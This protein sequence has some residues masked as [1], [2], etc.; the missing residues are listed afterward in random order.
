MKNR[1]PIN[2]PTW[3]LY[4][5]FLGNKLFLAFAHSLTL[6]MGTIIYLSQYHPSIGLP[7]IYN[8]NLVFLIIIALCFA[9]YLIFLFYVF[10]IRQLKLT[11]KSL[12]YFLAIFLGIIT[13]LSLAVFF[14]IYAESGEGWSGFEIFF[15][16]SLFAI[17]IS[18]V[19]TYFSSFN[20]TMYWEKIERERKNQIEKENSKNHETK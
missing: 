15:F 7:E 6:F 20:L 4:L 16:I 11:K 18:V 9:F 8:F 13:T 14:Y 19:V 1:Q 2:P 17:L 3:T 10:S 12:W 5:S